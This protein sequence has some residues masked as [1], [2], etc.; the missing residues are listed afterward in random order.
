M[1][2]TT[3]TFFGLVVPDAGPVFAAVL[4]AHILASLTCVITGALAATA[5]KRAGRHPRAGTVYRYGIA[6]VFATATVMAALRWADDWYLFIIGAVAFTAVTA[7]YLARR[8]RWHSW[9]TAHIAGM[10]VSYIALLTA[11]YVD[12]GPH[13]PLWNRF[14]GL[15]FWVGPCLIGIPLILSALARHR[16]KLR[17]ASLD[18]T[19]LHH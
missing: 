1:L 19:P 15:A 2:A 8:R 17:D 11:F 10:G 4:V 3:R 5:P 6:V 18:S 12:N 14:P 9:L 16:P 13:L 7:G